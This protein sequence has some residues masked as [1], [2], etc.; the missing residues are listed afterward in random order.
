MKCDTSDVLHYTHAGINEETAN[1]NWLNNHFN[2]ALFLSVF[3]RLVPI[4]CR[5]HVGE[6]EHEDRQGS[7][8]PR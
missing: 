8:E 5:V 2:H 7:Q 6:E 4:V 3:A 1:N